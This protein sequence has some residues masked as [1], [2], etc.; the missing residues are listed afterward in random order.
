MPTAT[1]LGGGLGG[2]GLVGAGL[3]EGGVPLISIHQCNEHG[4]GQCKDLDCQ[5][6]DRSP[7]ALTRQLIGLLA[8]RRPLGDCHR[9]RSY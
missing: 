5:E 9:W 1:T 4:Y 2:M 6:N 3:G 8:A 7:H